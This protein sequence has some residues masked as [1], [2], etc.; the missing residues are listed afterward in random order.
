MSDQWPVWIKRMDPI[1]LLRENDSGSLVYAA[2]VDALQERLATAEAERLTLARGVRTGT[3]D[4]LDEVT[5]LARR[6]VAEA[7][8]AKVAT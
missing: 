4:S 8:A 5:P 6:I 3:G 2:D 7:D 1:T